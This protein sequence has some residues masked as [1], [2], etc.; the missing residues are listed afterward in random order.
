MLT[1]TTTNT[2]GL[3]TLYAIVD[4][5]SQSEAVLVPSERWNYTEEEFQDKA[6]IVSPD[7]LIPLQEDASLDGLYTAEIDG[8]DGLTQN[9]RIAIQQGNPGDI[10]G[11]SYNIPVTGVAP[12][13][14]I[15]LEVTESR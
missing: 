10:V 2:S 6:T 11:V 4:K 3:T 9:L 7:H 14:T 5:V 8:M 12:S 15:D 1:I 13:V